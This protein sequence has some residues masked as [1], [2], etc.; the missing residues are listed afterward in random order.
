MIPRQN[1]TCSRHLKTTF[2]N[3]MKSLS[4]LFY[5]L[6]DA[7]LIN[8]FGVTKKQNYAYVF[9]VHPRGHKDLYKKFPLFKFLPRIFADWFTLHFWPITVSNVTGLRSKKSNE[10]IPG[11]IISIPLTARQII[12]HRSVALKKVRTAIRLGKM[13]G[14]KIFGLGGLVSS[15]TKGGL[16]LLDIDGALI[17]TGHAYTGFNVTNNIFS[18]TKRLNLTPNVLTVAI[19]GAAGSIGSLSALLLARAKYKR[20]HL[21]D[22]E[23]KKNLVESL[24]PELTRLNPG[25]IVTS[26]HQISSI[27]DADFIVAATNAPEALI[28]AN[29][30]KPGAIVVD[31]AQPSDVADDVLERDDVLAIEAG[32]VSTPGIRSNFNLGLK[33]PTDNFC[34]MA[35]LLVLASQ[36]WNSHYVINRATLEHVD[37]ISEW[38]KQLG[39]TLAQFQNRKE[40]ISEEK[41]KVIA[42]M[43]G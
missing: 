3:S 25:V 27:R 16:D 35:E 36:E 10:I 31:D 33:D 42:R 15:V 38:G 32:V 19:V 1:H 17:T 4:A 23:R 2:F 28:T 40:L 13:K 20:I 24:V 18:L 29:D 8:G 14:A 6:H 26:S 12:E 11:Y 43:K 21:V 37:Q 30:L 7:L 9:I 41:L 34:C 22:L 5:A 39:F